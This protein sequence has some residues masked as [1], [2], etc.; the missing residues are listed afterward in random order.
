MVFVALHQYLS[1]PHFYLPNLLQVLLL[2]QLPQTVNLTS[3][4]ENSGISAVINA[5]TSEPLSLENSN[6]RK[7]PRTEEIIFEHKK[8]QRT[9]G[10]FGEACLVQTSVSEAGAGAGLHA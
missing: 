9:S 3:H 6:L 10:A 5:G 4:A 7:H 1:L 2:L 8:M